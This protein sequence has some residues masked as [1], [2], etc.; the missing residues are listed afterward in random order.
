MKLFNDSQ[1]VYIDENKRLIQA[2]RNTV[3]YSDDDIVESE[4]CH[5]SFKLKYNI[6]VSTF[7]RIFYYMK[8]NLKALI[9]TLQYL[10]I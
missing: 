4:D 9:E 7:N 6:S 8:E 5:S 10:K 3:H 2:L 1:I